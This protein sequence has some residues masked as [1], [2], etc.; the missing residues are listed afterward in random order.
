MSPLRT[1]ELRAEHERQAVVALRVFLFGGRP[2]AVCTSPTIAGLTSTSCAT[3]YLVVQDNVRRE[4]DAWRSQI[5]RGSLE[6]AVLLLLRS[7]KRYGLEFVEILNGLKL[8]VSEGSIYPLLS[9]LRSGGL[10]RAEWVEQPSGGH[11]RK[12]YELTEAGSRVCEEEVAVW[13][14]HVA[15]FKRLTGGKL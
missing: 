11:A 1:V 15:A 6:L 12:Y 3:R 14:E 13:R 8:G 7:R 9:R 4:V 2:P 5:L 10:V